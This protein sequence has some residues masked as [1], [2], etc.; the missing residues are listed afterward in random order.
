MILSN[1]KPI[2]QR[3]HYY[4]YKNG[5]PTDNQRFASVDVTTGFFLWKK[6]VTRSITGEITGPWTFV[7]T[8]EATPA[9]QV[10]GLIY[11]MQNG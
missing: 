11:A 2:P 8:G 7:D 5:I 9:G 1:L 6:V 10:E 4:D 3:F